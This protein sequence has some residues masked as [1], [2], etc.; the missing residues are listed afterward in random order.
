MTTLKEKIA[1][2]WYQTSPLTIFLKPLSR[3]YE[4]GILLRKNYL[5][6]RAVKI[7]VP[8]IVIGNITVGGTGKTP[9]IMKLYEALKKE[10]FEPGIVSRGYLSQLSSDFPILL[11]EHHGPEDVGDE[12]Y[13]IYRRIKAP[14]MICKDRVKAIEALL[15]MM[16]S[17]NVILS[18]DGLQHY[19]MR[20]DIEVAVIDGDRR[21][22]N[23]ELLPAGPLREP[24]SRLKSVDFTVC[25]GT[26]Q[27]DEFGM[28][29]VGDTLYALNNPHV[30]QSLQDLKSMTVHAV[31]GIGHPGRFFKDLSAYGLNVISHPYPDHHLFQS[32]DFSFKTMAPII[33]TEKDAVKCMQLSIPNAWY[34]PVTAEVDP[35]LIEAILR[36]LRHG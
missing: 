7:S 17:I 9:L 20:R 14:V 11:K 15:T 3:L 31:A 21:F 30:T 34:L 35:N 32:S 8:V 36:K 5:T 19:R 6:K 33:M 12:P 2:S 26:P 1:Q 25:Q 22:G 4:K 27:G 16:P 29:L 23:G 28:K 24:V 10:G 13:M 18:D